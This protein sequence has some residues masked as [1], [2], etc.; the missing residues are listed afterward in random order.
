MKSSQGSKKPV[1]KILDEYILMINKI[2]EAVAKTS[3]LDKKLEKVEWFVGIFFLY[4]RFYFERKKI[5]EW[6]LKN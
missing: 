2:G 6:F 1:S 3:R 5:L 4:K